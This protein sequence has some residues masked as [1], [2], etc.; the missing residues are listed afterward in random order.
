MGKVGSDKKILEE[1]CKSRDPKLREQ[2]ILGH[3]D[4]VHRVKKQYMGKGLSADT[5]YSV[6]CIGLIQA[7]DRFD[8]TEGAQFSTYAHALISGEIKHH[9]R[10]KT[11]AVS[12]PR[13]LKED[14]A[15]VNKEIDRFTRKFHRSPSIEQLA[16]TLQLTE[17]RVIEAIEVGKDYYSLS[18]D[19]PSQQDSE[20]ST[21]SLGEQLS[22]DQ[23]TGEEILDSLELKEVLHKLPKRE[24]LVIT[25]IYL[26]DMSQQKVADRLEISQNHV[27]RLLRQ[28]IAQ[29]KKFKT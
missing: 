24:Q 1:Y 7:V 15:K 13:S 4:L 17:E 9:F 11:W 27:S 6:G 22:Q 19:T 20:S 12:I 16:A 25:L 29:L 5:L 28:G 10:D 26:H 8:P 14:Y 3:L 2:I 23:Q 18:L 21:A